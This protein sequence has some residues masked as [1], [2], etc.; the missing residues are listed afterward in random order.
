MGQDSILIQANQIQFPILVFSGDTLYCTNVTGVNIYWFKDTVAIDSLV[1]Y[2]VVTQN[3]NYEVFVV[4][5]NGCVGADSISMLNVSYQTSIKSD[6]IQ[7]YPNPTQGA[8]N[9]AFDMKQ[10]GDV[11]L[12]INDLLGKKVYS[13]SRKIPYSG[14]QSLSINLEAFHLNTGIYFLHIILG[15]K[16]HVLKVEYLR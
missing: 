7:V 10:P 12:M 9:I 16:H 6:L 2:Y 13:S 1:N 3:G 5:S 4:D 11:E 15:G 14:S 8:I